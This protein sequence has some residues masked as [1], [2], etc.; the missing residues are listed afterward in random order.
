MG[1]VDD[2][3]GGCLYESAAAGRANSETIS[4]NSKALQVWLL[5]ANRFDVGVADV[6]GALRLLVAD[7]A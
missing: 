2:F 5:S 1:G 7:T 6:V 3:L 4:G